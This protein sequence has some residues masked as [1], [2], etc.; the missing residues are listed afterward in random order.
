[1]L[2]RVFVRLLI[3]LRWRR[4]P[5][6]LLGSIRD[7]EATEDDSAW[8]L[9]QASQQERKPLLRA[10]L[11]TQ[12]LEE[13]HHAEVFRSLYRSL[14]GEALRKRSV[15]RKRL[16]SAAEGWKL[17]VFCAV[18]ERAAARRFQSIAEGL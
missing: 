15:P 8:H 11:F 14:S 7:F 13:S 6:R 9:L 2:D 3:T 1:M 18:G 4:S 5:E 10:R 16:F 12:A 17:L